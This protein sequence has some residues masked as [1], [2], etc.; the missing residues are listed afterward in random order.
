MRTT[1][2]PFLFLLLLPMLLVRV[3]V[4][5]LPEV[6]PEVLPGVLPDVLAVA[7]E[8]VPG[9]TAEAARESGRVA[10]APSSPGGTGEAAPKKQAKQRFGG[11]TLGGGRPGLGLLM[12]QGR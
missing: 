4:P 5:A 3:V 7:P 8:P 10:V 12:R 9:P 6:L 11:I 2:I 1:V